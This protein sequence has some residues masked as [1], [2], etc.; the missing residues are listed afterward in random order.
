[1]L[2][3]PFKIKVS[4]EILNDLHDRLKRTRWTDEVGGAG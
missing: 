1:M 3:K 4:E 2:I